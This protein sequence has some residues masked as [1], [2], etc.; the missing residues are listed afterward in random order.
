MMENSFDCSKDLF[1]V[2]FDLGFCS[3]GSEDEVMDHASDTNNK[4]LDDLPG[5]RLDIKQINGTNWV[6]NQAVMSG[7]HVDNS[8]SVT[9]THP[10]S[11][12]KLESNL[13]MV[14]NECNK[15]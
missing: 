3:T 8:A 7:A 12:D 6:S 4:I 11:E 9:T 13:F 10:S 5:R 2:T 14:F 15:K 1:S